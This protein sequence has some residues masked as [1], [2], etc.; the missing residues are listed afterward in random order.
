MGMLVI[1][2]QQVL[3]YLRESN[4]HLRAN[5]ILHGVISQKTELLVTTAVKTSNHTNCTTAVFFIQDDNEDVDMQQVQCFVIKCFFP[6]RISRTE[7]YRLQ[8]SV[9]KEIVCMFPL[10][11]HVLS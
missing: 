3:L 5:N 1:G 8:L 6:D 2:L 9:F 7:M 4:Q 10:R 11:L